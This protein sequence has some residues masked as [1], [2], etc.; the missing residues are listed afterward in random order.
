MRCG[1]CSTPNTSGSNCVSCGGPLPAAAGTELGAEPP[2]A[3]R[4]LPQIYERRVLYTRNFGFMFGSIFGGVGLFISAIFLV[5]A[6][7][8]P[9]MLLGVLISGIFV[10]AGAVVC[11]FSLK[12]AGARLETLRRGR[13]T[14]GRVL[15]VGHDT[16]V[17][18][19]G[20]S[21]WL[22]EYVFDVDGTRYSGSVSSFD[23][24]ITKYAAD[25][26]VYVVYMADNPAQNGTWPLLA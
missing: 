14:V 25:N 24:E 1:W 19:N 26:P 17:R 22:L 9:P 3:P 18:V 13:V 15:G 5:I 23:A 2:R 7:G 4:T 16:S 8:F 21:P 6:I 10:V 20:R 11:G 12:S